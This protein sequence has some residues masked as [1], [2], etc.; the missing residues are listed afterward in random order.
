VL[1]CFHSVHEV[2]AALKHTRNE[3]EIALPNRPSAPPSHSVLKHCSPQKLGVDH[4]AQDPNCDG[5]VLGATHAKGLM[6]RAI[7]SGSPD[8]AAASMAGVGGI[9]A[10]LLGAAISST[11]SPCPWS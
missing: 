9:T 7:A 4:A 2:P 8:S 11:A 5:H 6:A 10:S 1:V 3:F